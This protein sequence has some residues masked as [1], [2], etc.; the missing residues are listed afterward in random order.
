[1]TQPIDSDIDIFISENG[2]KTL[3][4]EKIFYT[5]KFAKIQWSCDINQELP[6]KMA[7]SNEP[8]SE[9]PITVSQAFINQHSR[10]KDQ[11]CLQYIEDPPTQQEENVSPFRRDN[12]IKIHE[13]TWDLYY[14]MSF[15][16]AKALHVLGISERSCVLIQGVNRPEHMISMMGTT[17]SNCIYTDIYMTN[18]PKVCYSQV[19]QTKARIIVCDTYKR[20]RNSFLD[21]HEE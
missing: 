19:E 3:T 14:Q 4:E 5:S 1:M 9:T 7:K 21:Q 17:L 13:Y 20:L 18:N 8:G 15:A 12:Q 10:L 11:L 16:F 6:I 2:L